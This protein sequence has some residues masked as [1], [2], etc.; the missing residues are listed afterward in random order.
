MYFHIL[1][2]TVPNLSFYHHDWSNAVTVLED[3]DLAV[4]LSF[5]SIKYYDTDRKALPCVHQCWHHYGHRYPKSVINRIGWIG[6]N[7]YPIYMKCQWDEGIAEIA[8]KT[9][10]WKLF[11]FLMFR[12]QM[13][14]KDPNSESE[15]MFG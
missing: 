8:K 10:A 2:E 11:F 13:K 12:L 9:S 4:L 1:N 7:S 15:A 5:R 14:R 6:P 3:W